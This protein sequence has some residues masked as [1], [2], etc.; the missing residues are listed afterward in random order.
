MILNTINLIRNFDSS[1]GPPP[2]GGGKGITPLWGPLF[3]FLYL[4]FIQ[5]S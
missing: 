2:K 5:A 4:N 3:Y 1:K